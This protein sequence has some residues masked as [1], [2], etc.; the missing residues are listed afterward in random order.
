M[1]K[2]FPAK[3]VSTELAAQIAENTIESRT[4]AR[5]VLDKAAGQKMPDGTIYLGFYHG[6][7]W[8]VTAQDAKDDDE[9]RLVLNFD[10][11]LKFAIN[12]R[13]HTFNDWILPPSYED[14][15]ECSIL[16]QM[17]QNRHEGMFRGTYDERS[18]YSSV[19]YWSASSHLNSAGAAWAQRFSDGC[20][21]WCKKNDF[22]SVRCVRASVRH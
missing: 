4:A 13:A 21:R 11:A 20:L 6:K 22:F 19:W 9:K 15:K 7:D 3:L 1:N 5:T 14:R 10:A 18:S 12:L 8:Y 17:F 16:N 2:V